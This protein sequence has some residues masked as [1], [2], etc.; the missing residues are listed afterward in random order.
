MELEHP[1]PQQ[2]S[3]YSFKLVGDMTLKQFFQVA[4][5]TLLSLVIY[6]TSL[7]AYVKWPL[8]LVVF[9]GGIAFAFF[10][11]QDRP[12]SQWM[13]LFFKAIYSPTLYVWKKTEKSRE[14]FQ[15]EPTVQPLA[16]Q[17]QVTTPATISTDQAIL[18]SEATP[19]EVNTLE[20]REQEFLNKVSGHFQESAQVAT[21][22]TPSV[23]GVVFTQP[24]AT[25]KPAATGIKPG[26]T[27]P[28]VV[29]HAV[30]KTDKNVFVSQL[31]ES[32]SSAVG[33]NISPIAEHKSEVAKSAVFAPESA[34]PIPPTIP[35]IVVGQVMDNEGKI[36]ENAILEIK[37]ENGRSVRALK[38]NRLGHFMI[39]TPL[40]PGKYEVTTEKEGFAFEPVSL[41]VK[42]EII[43]PISITSKPAVS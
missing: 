14:Y 3:S 37:D 1:I 9:L 21:A 15:P 38:S 17:A 10:P 13:L 22:A 43:P 28:K 8:I 11:L 19:K 25:Q 23:A 40:S 7:P 31:T 33:G 24:Q 4:G 29:P 18:T 39:V 20:I 30:E 27:V 41:M 6:S 12:L 5:G 2:I 34:P 35:N 42:G 36:I 26:V 32:K 16:G